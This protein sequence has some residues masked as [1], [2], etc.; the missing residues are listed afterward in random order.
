MLLKLL[1]WC[2][3][4]LGLLLRQK[5]YPRF[6]GQC[7]RNVLFGRFVTLRGAGKISIG[8]GVVI[9]DH[10]LLNADSYQMPG[11]GIT[12]E[13]NVFIGTGTE[14]VSLGKKIIIK[15]N[16]SL[17]SDCR[18]MS[19][20]KTIIEENV[21]LAAYCRVGGT[22]YNPQKHGKELNNKISQAENEITEIG[23][24]CWLGVRTI[25][26]SG[27]QIGEGT[28]IGAHGIVENGLPPKVVAVGNPAKVLY[29]RVKK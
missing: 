18:I 10:A 23:A 21:L 7:G 11:I 13:D 9:N 1:S 3:G 14:I 29:S 12:V 28:I 20:N 17:G 15:K 19:D 4:A 22:R 2:P 27:V 16:T 25:F 5:L 6:L 24:G 8:S 26:H